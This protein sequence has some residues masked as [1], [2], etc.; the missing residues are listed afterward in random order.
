VLAA[1]AAIVIVAS[2]HHERWRDEVVPLS[3]ARDSPTI[4]DVWRM[5]RHEGHPIL[6]YLL[7]RYAY[8][9]F[10]TTSVLG[11]LSVAIAIAA[12]AV[13]LRRAPIPLPILCLFVFGYFPLYEYAVIARANGLAMLCLFA[14]CALYR[15]DTPR[16]VALAAALAG[17]ANSTAQGF[18]VAAAVG[19]M[20]AI[21]ALTASGRV[22]WSRGWTAAAAIYVAGLAHAVVSNAPDPSV[23]VLPVYHHDLHTVASDILR[24]ALDPMGSSEDFYGLRFSAVWLWTWFL[25]LLRR[26]GLL[27]FTAFGLI[28]FDL[29]FS[30]V[31]AA[32]DRHLGYVVILVMAAVWLGHPWDPPAATRGGLGP[33]AAWVARRV[34]LVPLVL[35]LLHQVVLG[36]TMV[37]DDVRLDYSSSRRLASLIADDPRLA[38]AIVIGEPETMAESLPYYVDNRVFLPQENAFRNWLH[39]QVAGGR[40]GDYDLAELLATAIALRDQEGVPVLVALG[41]SLDDAALQWKYYGSFFTQRFT[42]TPAARAEFRARTEKLASFQDAAFTDENYDVF[43]VW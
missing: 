12:V 3:I 20:I 22:R 1:Y 38:S 15:A 5:M 7:L 13:L 25:L 18:L 6:W 24:A 37:R 4:V 39:I 31:Y 41:W 16:P 2:L 35:V 28:G 9:A 23:T 42:M 40:R 43:V 21:E 8:L 26:P 32:N 36:A 14:F 27:A 17:L 11:V 29:L 33:R 19:A 34:L 10:G 30:L